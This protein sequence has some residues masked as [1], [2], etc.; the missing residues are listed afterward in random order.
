MKITVVSPHRGDAAF[1][2]G[3]SIG[4]WLREG[5]A[6]EVV[7]CFTRS[8]FAP[9]SDVGLLHRNDRVSF[10][11]AV[12]KR[13]DEAWRKQVGV[14]K[15]TITD[16]NLKDAP[17]R[18]HI[19]AN[20]VFGR[21][22]DASEKVVAKIKRALEMSKAGAWVLPL[23]LGGHVDH[24]TARNVALSALATAATPVAFYEE[25]PE[26][27][28]VTGEEAIDAVVVQLA[29]AVQSK[30]EPAL[31]GGAGL[32]DVEDA[33]AKKRRVAWCYDSQIDEAATTD[34]AEFCRRFG[35]AERIWTNAAWR[36]QG[37]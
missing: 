18:L 4:A 30:L 36:S 35:G 31:A 25:L 23:G 6:V 5:H 14:A 21:V 26:A 32:T 2:L 1:A 8:E 17:L 33:V 29:L 22:A 13:E 28:A 24:V 37:L 20:E 34:I 12:R 19:G 3:L 27:G 16:L 9:Y 15:F 10:V 7:S 11:T